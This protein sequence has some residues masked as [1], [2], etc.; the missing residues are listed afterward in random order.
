MPG[1]HNSGELHLCLKIN[2]PIVWLILVIFTDFVFQKAIHSFF[3]LSF[4]FF[5]AAPTAY[6]SSQARDLI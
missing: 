4:F 3:F 5:T 6:G 2:F 1:I